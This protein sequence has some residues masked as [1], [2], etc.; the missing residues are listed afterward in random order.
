MPLNP[1][2]NEFLRNATHR[3]N[4]KTGATRSGKTYVDCLAVIPKRVLDCTGSGLIVILGNTQGTVNRN[5]LEPMRALWG[6]QR[7]GNIRT[8]DGAV[9]M[10]GKKVYVLG[11]DKANSVEKIQGQG[12][13]Y[14]YGDEVT[15]WHEDVFQMLKSRLDKPNSV[16][17]G[18]C[19]PAGP[20]HW[21]KVFLDSDADIYQQAY[22]I[23]DNPSLPA[24]FVADLKREYTGTV[25]YD[26][27]ILG[28]W[29]AAEG[30]IYRLFANDPDAY[31]I[32][33][34]PDIAFATIGVDFGGTGS[35][36]AFNCT[37]FLHG[38]QGIVTLDEYYSKQELDANDLAENFVEFVQHQIN[39]GYTI[40]EIR[41]DSAETVLI[42]TLRN[43][44]LQAGIAIPVV[45]AIKSE[46]VNRIRFYGLLIGARR[47]HVMA[48]C[49]HTRDA[50][51]SALWDPKKLK[52]TRLD[53]GTTN[54]DNLDAQEYSTEPY[55]RQITDMIML[56]GGSV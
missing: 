7:V 18:T 42:R 50:F 25:F 34:A 8:T 40:K 35:G 16:F 1:K 28:K 49:V 26:R 3:W 11:A 23:D 31:T 32:H 45:N 30:V 19:N 56:G 2:Q 4:F 13:E 51:A 12:M 55:Q 53:D 29:I 39:A 22:T 14:C 48:H 41:M 20:K 33:E 9:R 6:P 21:L 43:A 54:I 44:L 5:V 17:D 10:F 37:G 24:K 27:Y 38:F 52:D 46:I 15:T 47:Y 36:Q